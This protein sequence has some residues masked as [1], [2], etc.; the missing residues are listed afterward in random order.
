M[1]ILIDEILSVEETEET[2]MD[3]RHKQ[4]V[5]CIFDTANNNQ[6]YAEIY[7]KLYKSLMEKYDFC[8]EMASTIIPVYNDSLQNIRYIDPN[9]DYDGFC[10]VNKENEKR[11]ANWSFIIH[12]MKQDILEID[13]LVKV[14][15]KMCEIIDAQMDDEKMSSI[16][17]E[18]TANIFVLISS[19]MDNMMQLD[20]WANI[21]ERIQAYSKYKH[22]DHPGLSSRTIFKY[23]DIVDLVKKHSK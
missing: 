6:F 11:K 18:I 12:L 5:N 13:H 14:F 9:E 22:K 16:T 8:K 2:P 1:I 15:D 7:A 20:V 17:D 23:M 4:I 19:A 3:E 10:A 21:Y